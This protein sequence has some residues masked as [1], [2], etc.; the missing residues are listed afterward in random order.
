MKPLTPDSLLW[1][2]EQGRSRHPIDR[3]LLLF[4]LGQPDAAV[5][6]LAD[7][8]LGR[9]HATLIQ[10]RQATFGHRLKGYVDCPAC[11]QRQEIVLDATDLLA[12]GSPS[13]EGHDRVCVDGR[14]FRLPTSRDLASIASETDVDQA[15]LRLLD[16]CALDTPGLPRTDHAAATAWVDRVASAMDE[17]DPL[18]NLELRLVCDSCGQDSTIPFDIAAF[19]WEE[20]EARARGLLDEVHL[21][22]RAYGWGEA[23]ILA[24][25]ESRRSAYLERVTA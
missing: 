1:A 23:E 17:A 21:L 15:A 10:L 18:A 2:W 20:I 19:L 25:S 24:L 3:A 5:D 8:P 9:C 14:D 6:S 11:A 16:A 4:A 12:T 22:A 7:Q 13:S